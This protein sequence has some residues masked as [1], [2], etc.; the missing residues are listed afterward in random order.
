MENITVED[1]Q[2]LFIAQYINDTPDMRVWLEN[3]VR[4]KLHAQFERGEMNGAQY[5]EAQA[6]IEAMIA[7]AKASVEGVQHNA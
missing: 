6:D 3:T 7:T 2:N 1:A 5:K 4:A